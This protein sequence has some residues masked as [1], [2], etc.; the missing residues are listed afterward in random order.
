MA[1]VVHY[2]LP[3]SLDVYVHRSGRTG[4]AGAEGLSVAIV[5]PA[6]A[7][8][9]AALLRALGRPAPPD[10]PSPDALLP[11]AARRVRLA[12]RLDALLR[13]RSKAGADA[14]WRRERAEELGLALS[15]D[16]AEGEDALVS[17]RRLGKRGRRVREDGGAGDPRREAAEAAAVRD[18]LARAL[19]EPLQARFNP[20][21]FAGGATAG[22]AAAAAGE[23]ARG[24][25]AAAPG[26]ALAARS[27]AMAER[28]A[29]ARGAA[30]PAAKRR[31]AGAG[32]EKRRRGAPPPGS[33]AAALEAAL[34]R[35]HTRKTRG[36]GRL[37]VV[38]PA[39]GRDAAGPGALEMLRRSLGRKA[40]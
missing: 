23:G 17:G 2:Q 11:E 19:A 37:V 6:E 13:K 30:T 15:E 10:F 39:L 5:T 4:R 22:V 12:V 16:D 18:E 38:P 14:A 3:A 29:A 9:F 40:A 1:L 26:G 31:A 34:E 28:A 7:G 27:I 32:G 24:A 20:R 36:R 21:F 8:R 35:H 33:R 25:A